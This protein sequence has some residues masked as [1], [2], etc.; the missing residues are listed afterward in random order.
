MFFSF[1]SPHVLLFSSSS[2][3]P[4]LSIFSLFYSASK[5]YISFLIFSFPS[6]SAPA[7]TYLCSSLFSFSTSYFCSSSCSS[8]Y[9]SHF[10]FSSSSFPPPPPPLAAGDRCGAGPG[11]RRPLHPVWDLG[12]QD[13][14]RQDRRQQPRVRWLRGQAEDRLPDPPSQAALEEVP[15]TVS[16]PGF[17]HSG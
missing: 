13:G 6:A 1:S 16:P 4:F 2:T 11:G 10:C 3:P 17:Q 5:S 7:S 8:A 9:N 15:S 14:V 12:R